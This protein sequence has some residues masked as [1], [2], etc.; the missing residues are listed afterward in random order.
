L[1]YQNKKAHLFYPFQWQKGIEGYFKELGFSKITEGITG[2]KYRI[3]NDTTVTYLAN[4]LDSIIIIDD[5]QEI[6]V[7]I[8]DSLHA[9]HINVIDAFCTEIK[10]LVGREID[11]AFCGF[12]GASWF[13]NN[14]HCEG[15][16]D[17]EIGEV[18]EQVF[19]HNF[20]KIVD[21]LQ[22]KIAVPFAADFA[23]LRTDQRWI[24]TTR[25]DRE[26]LLKYYND[27]F[28][29]GNFIRTMYSGDY[30]NNGILNS[31][32]PY[33]NEL[34]KRG[35]LDD[36]I[37]IQ[38]SDEIIERNSIKEKSESDIDKLCFDILN[39]INARSFLFTKEKLEEVKYSLDF[40]GV[41]KDNYLNIQFID[42]K[43]VGRRSNSVSKDSF[44]S[45]KGKPEIFKYSIA[46]EW[47]GDAITIGYGADMYI[48]D[49][50]ILDKGLDSICTQLITRHP[51]A[52][53]TI[54]KD[55]FR[56]AKYFATNK[57]MS[58]FAL[59]RIVKGD[60]A[61]SPS[62]NRDY[63]LSKTKCDVCKVC[64]IPLLTADFAENL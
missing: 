64:D 28:G 13:P 22:P 48:Y 45:I 61:K 47:G 33:R 54:K 15:K 9:H 50:S 44:L 2:K 42:N 7:N 31:V 8:N 36:L 58:K 12:G 38:Y 1:N 10:K 53:K 56:T 21:Q 27:Y 51:I 18:R 16:D 3:T 34:K 5:G 29:K 26:K 11:Y 6:L 46:S 63:W 52:S 55:L 32:S 40:I 24:N 4:G 43:F 30:I 49:K 37:D 60:G 62:Y 39:N 20:C 23:L 57:L 35:S 19:A 17:V 59:K 25:F 41:K 14:F